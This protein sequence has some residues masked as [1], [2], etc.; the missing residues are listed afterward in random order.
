MAAM[1]GV[2][3]GGWLVLEKWMTPA[4]FAGTEAVDEYT[5]MQTPEAAAK[6]ERHREEF[7]R[8]SDFAWLAAHGIEAVRIPVG[9]WILEGDASYA[10]G[11]RYLDW[12]MDMA[13]KYRLKVLICLHA[14]PGSQNGHDHSG[15]VGRAAWFDEVSYRR[16]SVEVL[17]QIARR[18]RDHDALWGI[19][20][21]NEPRTR[22][23]QGKLRRFYREAYRALEAVIPPHV[24]IVF[25]DAFTPCLM[26]GAIR[27]Q[28]RPVAMD[29]HWYHFTY[30][31]FR[32]TPL[33][34]YYRWI[35]PHH[36]R[37]IG[38]L[39]RRQP[40]IIGEWSGVI[41]GEILG[42]YPSADHPA[43]IREHIV[44]QLKV[45]EAASAWF[46]WTYKTQEPGVW[47]YRSLVEDDPTLFE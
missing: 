44:R 18:Y 45:Y 33:E 17:E 20:L 41:A 35:I 36:R 46:Y 42:R 24:T 5:F 8:E 30:W 25:S 3:L 28:A 13:A 39:S 1:R 27:E 12:A 6:I 23:L 21:L 34:W 43:M 31:A 16:R 11:A 29:I 32:W 38:R 2:N 40:L 19:E 26:S 9:Y 15:R 22:L 7:I 14:A 4:L 37:L 47:N 10:A